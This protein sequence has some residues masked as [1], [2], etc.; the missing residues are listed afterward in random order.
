MLGHGVQSDAHGQT[1]RGTGQCQVELE[2][3]CTDPRQWHATDDLA[4]VNNVHNCGI[5][6][7]ELNEDVCGVRGEQTQTNNR[8]DTRDQSKCLH[9]CG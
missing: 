8:N 4:A 3:N 7:I 1:C 6:S 9:G 2:C 5:S